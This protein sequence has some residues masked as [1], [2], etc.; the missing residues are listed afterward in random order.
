MPSVGL[1]RADILIMLAQA[2]SDEQRYEETIHL[3][4]ATPYFV[5]WEGQSITWNLFHGA[6]MKRGQSRM[7]AK[8]FAG[9]LKDFEAALTYPEN[10]G[11]G[12]SNRPQEADAQYWRGKALQSLERVDEAKAAWKEGAAGP[13]GG[14]GD[15]GK[16][17]KLCQEALGE[18]R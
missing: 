3:L 7:E 8:D 13:G 15:Q 16:Y 4:E 14:R 18:N 17:R 11:V 10:I 1:R 6:H 9:A 12:R 2:Y 5:N